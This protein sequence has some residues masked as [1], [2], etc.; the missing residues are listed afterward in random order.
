[1]IEQIG[2]VV[3]CF[4]NLNVLKESIPSV[5]SDD[6]TIVVFDDN[7]SDGTSEWLKKNYPKIIQ[8]KGDGNNWWCGSLAKGIQKCLE[9][10]CN[11]IMSVNA[12][13]L[14]SPDSIYK[15]IKTSKNYGNSVIASL[16]VEVNDPKV[17]LW[18]GSYFKKIHSLI[19]IYSPKYILKAGNSIDSI[20]SGVYETDEVHGRGVLI[21]S[22]I[23]KLIGNYDYENFPHYGGDNDF[24]FRLKNKRIKMYIDPSCV[25]MAFADNTSL[26]IRKK[27]SFKEKYVMIYRYLFERKNGEAVY[28]W[29]K[30]YKKHLPFKYFI[31][32][33]LFIILLNLYRKISK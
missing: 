5:Y 30:L 15:L 21:P 1:M 25:S 18:A 6:F 7:S 19:P 4:D 12:D 24:S 27:M 33:Y 10:N 13:V 32:S 16:V 23:I 22:N 29:F 26:N 14:I 31:Q 20:G 2:V 11:Y 8:I 28:V 17:I 3:P 9:N